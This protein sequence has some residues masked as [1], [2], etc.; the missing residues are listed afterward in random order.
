MKKTLLV[1]LLV[2]PI[3]ASAQIKKK[4]KKKIDA[5]LE[6]ACDCLNTGFETI[7]PFML[8]FINIM[9]DKGGKVATNKFIE[10]FQT[11]NEQEQ[12]KIL[13]DAEKMENGEYG[14]AIDICFKDDKIDIKIMNSIDTLKGSYF[15]Y[16]MESLANNDSCKLL[17]S[18]MKIALA[19][20]KK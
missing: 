2:L 11:I 20:T 7:H 8:E 6:N 16:F 18:M 14:D 13:K 12:N 17:E 4:E 3:I 1:I 10:Y 19:E 15:N 9:A 5:Y